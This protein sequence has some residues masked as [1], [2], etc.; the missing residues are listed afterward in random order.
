MASFLNI[1]GNIVDPSVGNGQLL[2]FIDLDKYDNIDVYDIKVEYLDKLQ[3]RPNINKYHADFIVKEIETKHSE[4]ALS[5]GLSGMGFQKKA[6]V[7]VL[8]CLNK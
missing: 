4:I 3:K 8:V 5:L 2:K 6:A 7:L 1:N